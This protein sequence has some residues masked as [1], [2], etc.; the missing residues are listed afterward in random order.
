[1]NFAVTLKFIIEIGKNYFLSGDI[2]RLKKINI[3]VYYLNSQMY[4]N[5]K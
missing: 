4:C 5:R 2:I 1:M 3:D